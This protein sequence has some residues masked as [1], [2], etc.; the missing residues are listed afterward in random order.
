MRAGSETDN[1]VTYL[2]KLVALD[3]VTHSGAMENYIFSHPLASRD[4]EGGRLGL[5]ID[6]GD[7]ESTERVGDVHVRGRVRLEELARPCEEQVPRLARRMR[8]DVVE[9]DIAEHEG[10]VH[11]CLAGNRDRGVLALGTIS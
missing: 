6:G 5:R 3:V 11:G 2:D 8:L 4:D 10:N 1:E 9:I 7:V